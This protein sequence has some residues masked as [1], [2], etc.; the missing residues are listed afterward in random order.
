LWIKVP[1]AR[2]E[3]RLPDIAARLAVKVDGSRGVGRFA[4]QLL[5]TAVEEAHRL[6]AEQAARVTNSLL[7]LLDAALA[8][9][10]ARPRPSSGRCQALVAQAKQYVEARLPEESL[11]PDTVA[12]ALRISVRYLNRLFAAEA[13]PLSRWIMARRLERCWSA[14]HDPAQRARPISAIAYAWGFKS[15]PHFN[16]VF[17]SRYGCPPGSIRS[18]QR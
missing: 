3:H 6:S 8:P 18:T 4:A 11:A 17:R 10:V 9:P 12:R 15:V 2:L 5:Q 1:R 7:D 16:R 13:V 14:L